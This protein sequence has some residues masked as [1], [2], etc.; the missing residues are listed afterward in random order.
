MIFRKDDFLMCGVSVKP[1]SWGM[2]GSLFTCRMT[3]RHASQEQPAY[4]KAPLHLEL[5]Y[6]DEFYLLSPRSN[7]AG[8]LGKS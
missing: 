7:M 3:S 6:F 1:D 4:A 2:Q 8:N 5:A